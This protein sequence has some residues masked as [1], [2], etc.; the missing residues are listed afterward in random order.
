MSA[1]EYPASFLTF[2]PNAFPL[3]LHAFFMQLK[4]KTKKQSKNAEEWESTDRFRVRNLRLN[5]LLLCIAKVI[6]K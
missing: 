6:N 5:L 1:L 2:F 4:L 3:C